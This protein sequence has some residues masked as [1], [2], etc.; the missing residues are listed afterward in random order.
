MPT[1]ITLHIIEWQRFGI[2]DIESCIK[3]SVEKNEDKIKE[4]AQKIFCELQ[5]FAKGKG[6]HIF[7]NFDGTNHLKARN[8]VGL[9][10]TKSGVLEIYPKCTN[11]REYTDKNLESYLQDSKQ[12]LAQH[13]SKNS[14]DKRQQYKDFLQNSY[15]IDNNFCK[16]PTQDDGKTIR[17]NPKILLI[18]L[19]KTLK[20]SPFKESY[21]SSLEIA[22]MPLF[23]IF[24]AMFVDELHKLLSKGL[25]MNYISKEE[26]RTFLKGKLLFDKQI[27]YN[28]IHKERFFTA[29]DEFIADIAP[30]RLIK[31]TLHLLKEKTKYHQFKILQALERFDTI[32]LSHNYRHD[33]SQCHFTRYFHHY[34][35][36]MIWCKIFLNHHTFS[37]Y[38]GGNEAFA[39]LF[40]MEKLFEDYVAT[41][42]TRHNPKCDIKT[43]NSQKYFMI[44]HKGEDCFQLKPDIVIVKDNKSIIADTKWKILD[45]LND[46]KKFGISQAD[47]Y[48]MWA[49]VS[50]YQTNEVWLIYPLCERSK[51]LQEVLQKEAEDKDSHF[52]F[53]ASKLVK[54]YDTNQAPTNEQEIALK[55][56]FAPLPFV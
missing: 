44:N 3:N 22:K 17:E 30:N 47:L 36:I 27:K 5:D 48:Q 52:I 56:L 19:L 25:K 13:N 4:K 14:Q 53:K 35:H 2:S 9:I 28:L 26:N 37:P 11:L 34:K 15:N 6:N 8:F 40:S 20:D 7:L 1:N 16:I 54:F 23:E 33:F 46:T 12:D 51:A 50:K 29:S 21:I 55:I 41:M 31:S 43:Q 45:S 32:N 38:Q 10:Q 24:I 39:L 18:N 42:L 49:Y